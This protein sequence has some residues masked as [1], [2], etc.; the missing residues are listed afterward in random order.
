MAAGRKVLK[1]YALK[2]ATLNLISIFP[3]NIVFQLAIQ[4]YMKVHVQRTIILPVTEHTCETRYPILMEEHK[5]R[6]FET[7]LLWKISGP[8]RNGV[9][10]ECRRLHNGQLHDL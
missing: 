3:T 9:M 6:M 8:D 4:K 5:L 7:R 1:S 10:R 2:I